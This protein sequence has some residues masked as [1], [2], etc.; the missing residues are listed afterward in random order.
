ME[1]EYVVGTQE[2]MYLVLNEILKRAHSFEHKIRA[3][4]CL[5]RA[6]AGQNDIKNAMKVGFNVLEQLG[7]SFEQTGDK[8]A[9][10]SEIMKTKMMIDSKDRDHFTSNTNRMTDEKKLWT[11]KF[12]CLMCPYAFLVGS[13]KFHLLGCRMVHLTLAEGVSYDS[14]YGFAMLGASFSGFMEDP[15]EGYR[16]GKIA[17]ELLNQFS[18]SESVAR[19]YAVLY[20]FV[21]VWTE[22]LQAS[23][24]QLMI[25]HDSGMTAGNPGVATRCATMYV[26]YAFQSGLHLETLVGQMREFAKEM[27]RYKQIMSLRLLS[28]YLQ[29]ALNLMGSS[30]DPIVLTGEAMDEEAF[31]LE[32]T[33]KGAKAVLCQFYLR[34][35][36]HAYIFGRHG[37]A[38]DIAL[39]GRDMDIESSLLPKF[40]GCTFVF[41]EGLSALSMAKTIAADKWGTIADRAISKM[42]VWASYSGWN[43]LHRLELL[44]AEKCVLTGDNV[45]AASSYNKAIDLAK[46]HKFVHEE[47]IASERY[48]AFLLAVGDESS[49]MEQYDRAYNCYNNWGAARRSSDIKGYT[50][51]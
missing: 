10:M 45:G 39:K 47:A 35:L 36:V 22:P 24:P 31:L 50:S 4:Y 9:V 44:R 17:K 20:G 37:L 43:C 21:N 30:D 6:Y 29:S 23:L 5:M 8:A 25:G 11:M 49:S 3:Y 18:A 16:I 15:K 27:T 13:S 2:D 19:T 12:L 42:K 40:A 33:K 14:A 46:E 48:G 34:K 32:T 7:E 1:V 38:A 28:V 41:Y 26:N 51:T